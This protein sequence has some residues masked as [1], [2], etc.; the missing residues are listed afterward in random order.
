M[1][2]RP[3]APTFEALL[4]AGDTI[5]EHL[6][7]DRICLPEPE[8]GPERATILLPAQPRS[9]QPPR[10]QLREVSTVR[11]LTFFPS[12]VLGAARF[13]PARCISDV[14]SRRPLSAQIATQIAARAGVVGGF[15]GVLR[16]C[17][18]HTG[19][20]LGE[21]VGVLTPR[22]YDRF[23]FGASTVMF[24]T[25]ALLAEATTISNPVNRDRSP[26][27]RRG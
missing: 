15:F 8:L 13:D 23:T 12:A 4:H 25:A 26:G 16:G 6:A 10:P 22:F 2:V 3:V 5:V 7:C 21:V 18:Q 9:D 17:G 14:F 27:T 20:D 24:S 11:I 19:G 1:G